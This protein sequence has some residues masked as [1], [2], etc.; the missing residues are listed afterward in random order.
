[1]RNR[2]LVVEDD[3]ELV[4]LLYFNLTKAGFQ[5]GIATDG[6]R[7]LQLA[8]AKCPSLILLDVML[9]EL[10]GLAVCEILRRDQST[11]KIPIIILTAM[12]S[13]LARAAGLEAGANDY[14]AKPFS[15][16]DLLTR[17]GAALQLPAT[18]RASES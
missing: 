15:M 6:A 14:I 16:K 4:E 3:L 11:R 10:D 8:R 7:A 12:S 9:P 17:I 1:V 18:Y 2:I 13:Q 5:V